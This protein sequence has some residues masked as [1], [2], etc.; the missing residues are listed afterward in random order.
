[1]SLTGETNLIL[2][3][4][5]TLPNDFSDRLV[6]MNFEFQCALICT[7]EILISPD[8]SCAGKYPA[9][10]MVSCP[11]NKHDQLC[12]PYIARKQRSETDSW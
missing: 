10:Q 11:L 3:K 6:K 5:D 12:F 2:S 8:C 4:V 9:D 7:N 1:M